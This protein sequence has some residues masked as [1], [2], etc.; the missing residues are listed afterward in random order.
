[1]S[2]WASACSGV[3]GVPGW[4]SMYS[5][6]SGVSV[7]TSLYSGPSYAGSRRC[8]GGKYYLGYIYGGRGAS[9]E[10]G[11]YDY[12]SFTTERRPSRYSAPVRGRGRG[13]GAGLRSGYNSHCHCYNSLY[14]LSQ[15]DDFLLRI[16]PL[17]RTHFPCPDGL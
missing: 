4:A 12:G 15:Y 7:W 2:G 6:A 16:P 5:G 8:R 14:H 1:M 17:P 10:T 3:S 13:L 11:C 9:N